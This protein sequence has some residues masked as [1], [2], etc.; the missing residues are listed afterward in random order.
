[1]SWF[2]RL[3]SLTLVLL[4]ARYSSQAFSGGIR[5]AT[6]ILEH[7]DRACVTDVRVIFQM[8]AIAD[9]GSRL[10]GPDA[11][12]EDCKLLEETL[13]TFTNSRILVNQA[14][15][16][17][18]AR[19]VGR[20]NFWTPIIERAF[21]TLNEK[22]KLTLNFMRRKSSLAIIGTK[23]NSAHH[24]TAHVDSPDPSGHENSVTSLV[25]S[26][27][28]KWIVTASR[29]DTIIV[30]DT[31]SGAILHEWSACQHGVEAIALSPDS[32]LLVSAGR[33]RTLAIW[34]IDDGVRKVAELEGHKTDVWAC[35]WS[36]DGAL[37]ASGSPDKTVRVWDGRGTFQQCAL[38]SDPGAQPQALRFSPDSRYLAWISGRDCCV[39]QPLADEQPRRLTPPS[40]S[41]MNALSFDPESRC[42]AT[43]H[44]YS[45]STDPDACIVRVWDVATGA[46]LAVLQGHS[47]RVADISFSPDG[48]S[49]LSASDDGSARLWDAE[50]GEQTALF[51]DGD[52]DR[53]SCACFSPDGRYVATGSGRIGM[54]RLWKLGDESCAGTADKHDTSVAR[55]LFTPC[56]EFLTSGDDD[57]VVHIHRLSDFVG[58]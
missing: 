44:G 28:S 23:T 32:Q 34:A 39:W 26:H 56:G 19:R 14:D 22:G 41:V 5:S 55:I 12:L 20:A 11:P 24:G 45:N 29:D 33:H 1:M 31:S 4:P 43:A 10:S 40:Y 54:V 7:T 13:L 58:Y 30:W 27:D 46:V 15:N 16:Y 53:M 3:S 42:I 25:A 37:V 17:I 18:C 8:D 52:D 48:R 6:R 35:A 38:F 50:S 51:K 9:F 21:P 47:G 36:A 57:G 49:L 2:S